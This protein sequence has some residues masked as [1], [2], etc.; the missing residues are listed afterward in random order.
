MM[1]AAAVLM[2]AFAALAGYCIGRWHAD[3]DNY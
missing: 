2:V 1:E 3:K